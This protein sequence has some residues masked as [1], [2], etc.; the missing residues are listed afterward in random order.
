MRTLVYYLWQG[1]ANL[2]SRTFAGWVEVTKPNASKG[3][4][5]L[6]CRQPNLRQPESIERFVSQPG[7]T[8]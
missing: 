8:P 6:R 7:A 1:C 2:T 5:G 4:V 3:F